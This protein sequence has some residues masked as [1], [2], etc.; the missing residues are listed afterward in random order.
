MERENV[1]KDKSFLFA[2]RIVK[3]YKYLAKEKK[4][5]VLS[6]QLLRSGTAIGALVREAEFAQS[7][8][9]FINKMSIALKEANETEYWLMLLKESDYIDGNTYLSILNDC[10]ELLKLLISSINT[11]KKKIKK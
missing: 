6:K 5:N 4:E 1:L 8:P 2:L 11:S 3:A 10:Q 9:D 7:I